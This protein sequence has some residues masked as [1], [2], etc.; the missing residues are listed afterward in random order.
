MTWLYYVTAFIA[1][2]F[3]AYMAGLVYIR[4]VLKKEKKAYKKEMKHVVKFRYFKPYPL[5]EVLKKHKD[6]Y[7]NNEVKLDATLT[8]IKRK[9]EKGI[10]IQKELRNR[11]DSLENENRELRNRLKNAGNQ[12]KNLGVSSS[13][14]ASGKSSAPSFFFSI[15]EADGSFYPEKGVTVRDDRKYYWIVPDR[16]GNSGEL[17][18]ISGSYDLK[19]IENIDF[20]VIPVCEVENI[21][22]RNNASRIVQKEAGRVNKIA[23]RWVTDKKIKVKLM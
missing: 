23:G 15:P 21:S 13:E 19:A 12:Q 11:I 4:L 18:F 17:N 3:I 2:G 22:E 9:L 10:L 16:V 8:E 6:Q 20:Y 7:S 14:G 5:I 1:G